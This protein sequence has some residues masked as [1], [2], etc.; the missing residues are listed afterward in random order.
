MIL[1]KYVSFEAA[2]T[3]LKTKSL[4]FSH[5]EDFNDP[6]ECTGFGFYDLDVPTSVAVGHSEI[7]FLENM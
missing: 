2:L 6:F 3:I 7:S 1:Y 5:L 4:G